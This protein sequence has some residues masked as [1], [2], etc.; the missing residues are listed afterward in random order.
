MIV[1]LHHFPRKG[2]VHGLK[3]FHNP[4]PMDY[5]NCGYYSD[6]IFNMHSATKRFY[7]ATFGYNKS[8]NELNTYDRVINR[9]T[10]H[11][12]FEGKGSFNGQ[13][14][15]AGNVFIAPQKEKH[16]I[17]QDK[18]EPMTYGWIGLSGTE[19]ENQISLLHLSE[20]PMITTFQN[21]DVIH[22]IFLDTIYTEHP[23]VDLESYLFA[24][25]HEIMAYCNPVVQQST[26]QEDLRVDLYFSE[27][28]NYIETNYSKAITVSDIAKAVH[29]S[30]S[31]IHRICKQKADSTPIDLVNKKR[32]SVA[33]SMLSNSEASIGE[34][35]L[36]VGFSNPNAFSKFFTKHCGISAQAFRQ[37]QIE[38]RKQN[39]EIILLTEDSWRADEERRLKNIA[40]QNNKK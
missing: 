28:L 33:K 26:S 40:Q 17:I 4:M 15:Q 14:V 34:I 12:V 3:Y 23:N 30:S 7:I 31:Y 25:F 5:S 27:I 38:K 22:K 20:M 16:T 2:Q 37:Q 35:S 29:I 11:F 36:F 24:K 32:M 9:F 19:L 8:W 21:I 13:P 39:T 10:L 18:N 6:R 1:Y